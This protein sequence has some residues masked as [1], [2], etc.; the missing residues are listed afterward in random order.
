[1][2]VHAAAHLPSLAQQ[3]AASAQHI[4]GWRQLRISLQHNGLDYWPHAMVNWC[5]TCSIPGSHRDDLGVQLEACMKQPFVQP[6]LKEEA[7]LA[8]VTLVT[9]AGT[10]Q[11]G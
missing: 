9:G 8:E 4:G 5:A 7:S 3:T 11:A 10:G 2:D 1:M 6:T